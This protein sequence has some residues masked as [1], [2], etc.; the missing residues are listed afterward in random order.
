MNTR[1]VQLSEP[2]KQ[3]VSRVTH[4]I[5]GT[6]FGFLIAALVGMLSADHI[7]LEAFHHGFARI[8]HATGNYEWDLTRSRPS[9]I[10]QAPQQFGNN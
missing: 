2:A 8:N 1:Y 6:I 9:R 4:F 3:D 10:V 5:L 7:M